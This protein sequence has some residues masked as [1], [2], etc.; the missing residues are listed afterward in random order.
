LAPGKYFCRAKSKSNF[1]N[2]RKWKNYKLIKNGG[3][4]VQPKTKIESEGRG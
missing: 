4:V 2:F 1:K 3:S